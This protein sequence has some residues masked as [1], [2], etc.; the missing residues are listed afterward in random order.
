[1]RFPFPIY[2]MYAY[3]IYIVTVR[4]PAVRVLMEIFSASGGKFIAQCVRN[5]E[6]ILTFVASNQ[7][8]FPA[9]YLHGTDWATED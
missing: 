1:M 8:S 7:H 2:Y 9:P 3:I 6:N 5:T 4:N